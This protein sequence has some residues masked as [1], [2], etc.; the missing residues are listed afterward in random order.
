MTQQ[1]EPRKNTKLIV[2][3]L[4]ALV[5]VGLF[6][7]KVLVENKI[8]A[9][10]REDLSLYEPMLKLESADVGAS[11]LGASVTYKNVV[12]TMPDLP[13]MKCVIDKI[14][15]EG[16][17]RD[18]LMGKPGDVSTMNKVTMS[19]L[20]MVAE[21]YAQPLMEI[22]YYEVADMAFPY[23]DIK[24]ALLENK[25]S[26]DAL[27]LIGAMGPILQNAQMKS[28]AGIMR[29]FK[30]NLRQLAM[31]DIYL[32]LVTSSGFMELNK[33]LDGFDGGLDNAAYKTLRV[34]G[35]MAD[36]SEFVGTVDSVE[37]KGLKFNYKEM[38][39]ALDELSEQADPVK[40]L[41]AI[42][43]S[44]YNYKFDEVVADKLAVSASGITATLDKIYLGPRTLKEQGPNSIS[45]I[46]VAMGG[47][48]VFSLEAI[49]LE[50]MVL[51]DTI[52]DFINRPDA[53]VNDM[54]MLS[55]FTKQPLLALSGLAVNNLYIENLDAKGMVKLNNWRSDLSIDKNIKITSKINKFYVSN[56][57]LRQ[58]SMLMMGADESLQDI[59][60][61]LAMNPQGLTLDSGLAMDFDVQPGTIFYDMGFD[62]AALDQGS[63]TF[64][65]NGETAQP[66]RYESYGPPM[67]G[68]LNFAIEDKGVL[69]TLFKYLSMQGLSD[70]VEGAR[71]ALLDELDAEMTEADPKKAE[72]MQGIRT[73]LR[74]GGTL[75]IDVT[76]RTPTLLDPD[77]FRDNID[78][79]TINVSNSK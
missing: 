71:D 19:G 47:M 61:I 25:G 38:F 16:I 9:W 13:G 76:A 7:A 55:K 39:A 57:G 72:L 5:L 78:G 11:Y 8:K 70:T 75:N 48:D 31:C 18:T 56:T 46:K 66:T 60:G 44:L 54:S 22:G 17:D 26:E 52:V 6:V 30:M 33:D 77:D 27:A 73:F 69:N 35:D 24:A 74:Q 36:G 50:K 67:L 59:I 65:V 51:S 1:T 12:Y 53:Y 15:Q 3:G 32:G 64:K 42:I 21:D 37:L 68:R 2:A 45:D 28:G 23:R 14:T 29:D 40:M 63:L 41:V 34:T 79:L 10:A 62:L 43:P 58:L 20:R 49:G 4:I